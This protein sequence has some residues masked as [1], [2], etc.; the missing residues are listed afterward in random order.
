MQLQ[1]ARLCLDCDEGPAAQGALS[2]LRLRSIRVSRALGARTGTANAATSDDFAC[3][4]RVPRTDGAHG[5][6]AQARPVTDTKHA[7][8][9]AA[10]AAAGWIWRWNENRKEKQLGTTGQSPKPVL[11]TKGS[12]ERKKMARVER[13]GAVVP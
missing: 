1:I 11:I 5:G 7:L 6:G 3:C 10:I 4:R 8:G 13:D 9:V 12:S 2:C